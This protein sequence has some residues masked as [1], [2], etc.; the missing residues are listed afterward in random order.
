MVIP[1]RATY[2]PAGTVSTGPSQAA[3]EQVSPGGAPKPSPSRIGALDRPG[4]GSI[5]TGALAEVPAV[6]TAQFPT[7]R[8][9]LPGVTSCTT[10]PGAT[11]PS[12]ADKVHASAGSAQLPVPAVLTAAYTVPAAAAAGGPASRPSKPAAAPTAESTMTRARQ[13]AGWR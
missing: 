7:Y 8:A 10:P 4:N 11:W 12:A 6:L 1:V 9:E 5:V 2:S 13:A 3:V